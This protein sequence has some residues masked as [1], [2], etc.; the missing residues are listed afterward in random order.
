[1]KN[2]INRTLAAV[3]I[4]FCSVALYAQKGL[5]IDVDLTDDTPG[6]FSNPYFWIGVA[7]VVIIVALITRMGKK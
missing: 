5:D 3:M 6:I 7:A 2:L 1:M 4:T